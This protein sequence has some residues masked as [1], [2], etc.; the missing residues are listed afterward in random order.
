MA[1]WQPGSGLTLVDGSGLEKNT[2]DRQQGVATRRYQP[3][4]GD[5]ATLSPWTRPFRNEAL[6]KGTLG[7]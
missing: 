5:T 4:V 6:H 7:A 2:A 3:D 1:P